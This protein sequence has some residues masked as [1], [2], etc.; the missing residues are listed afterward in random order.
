MV[1]MGIYLHLLLLFY[2]IFLI[3]KIA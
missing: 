3:I 2:R 1:A